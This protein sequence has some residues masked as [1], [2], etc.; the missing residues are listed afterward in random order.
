MKSRECYH[1]A[2]QEDDQR[3]QCAVDLVEEHGL[4]EADHRAS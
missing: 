3:K 2:R 4:L 1:E